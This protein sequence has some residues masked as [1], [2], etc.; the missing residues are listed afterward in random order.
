V[1]CA[2][3]REFPAAIVVPRERSQRLRWELWRS[4]IA[5]WAWIKP[6]TVPILVAVAGM[7]FVLVSADYL[8]HVHATPMHHVTTSAFP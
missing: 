2:R 8:A 1:L 6:R 4:A 3:D 5:T 7:V